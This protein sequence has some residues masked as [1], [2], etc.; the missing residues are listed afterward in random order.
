MFLL[1]IYIY[2]YICMYIYIYIYVYIHISLLIHELQ[3]GEQLNEC[4][5]SER[6]SDF[7]LMLAMLVDDVREH[8][9]FN[10]P[11]TQAIQTQITNKTL[12]KELQLPNE[13][14]LAIKR[15][16]EIAQ[17]NQG[18]LLAKNRLA[19]LHLCNALQPKPLAFRNDAKHIQQQVMNN[20]SLYCQ[21]KH[22]KSQGEG[23]L[24]KRQPFDAAGW[25]NGI[26]ETIVKS[27]LVN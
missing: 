20:T 14:P 18:V 23:A 7:S 12:R 16:E 25:L 27:A 8:S 13:P 6:R 2:I 4:V 10:V 1:P 11:Q 3:L 22:S 24:N 26:E 15:A 17:F 19:E 5:H 9:Q 21:H